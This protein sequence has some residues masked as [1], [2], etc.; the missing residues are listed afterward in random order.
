[1]QVEEMTPVVSIESALL[2]MM[3]I[4][5][6]ALAAVFVLPQWLSGLTT[7]LTGESPKAFWYLSRASGVI[8]YLLLW[9]S[10]ALG[11][12][13]SSKMAR[14]WPGGP[15]AVDVH[16]FVS[17]LA[18]GVVLFHAFILLGD[19]YM[20]FTIAQLLVPFAGKDYRPLWVGWG[21]SAFYLAVPVAFSFY[22]RRQIG[23][24]VWRVLHY[25]GFLVYTLITIHALGSGT[26]ATAPAMLAIYILSGAV[27]YFLTTYRILMAG[28]VPRPN[29]R[30]HS[31]PIKPGAPVV[32][33]NKQS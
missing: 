2:L 1:V 21:Q 25:V 9:M 32:V 12:I 23:F 20:N 17:L 16:Q 24:R 33:P 5:L 18:L 4:A 13:T 30:A 28:R 19:R 31:N 8:A 11:L 10:V 7:S 14:V 22:A 6:G 29:P 15:A 26:D 27:V 3:G